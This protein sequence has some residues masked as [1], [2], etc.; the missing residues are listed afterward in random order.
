MGSRIAIMGAGAAGSYIGAFLT[1]DGEDVTLI[2]MWPEHVELMK[3]IGLRASGSQG[4]FTVPVKALHLT[5]A[6]EIK[7]P[8]DIVFLAV[9]SYDTEWATHFVKR[10]V[11]PSGFVASAQNCM[12]DELVTSIV[13]YGREV[14]C[15]MSHI[16]VAL[17]EPGHVIRGGEVGRDSGH[18]VFRVGELHGRI[19]PR[20]EH[21][22]SMLSSI[23]GAKVT[24]NI[25]GERWTKL[26]QN[27]MG[28]AVAAMSTLGSQ[29]MAKNPQ[30]RALR[31]HLARETVQV[32]QTLNF[33]LEPIA[34][35][36]PDFWARSDQG[37]VFEELDAY[38]ESHG[39]RVDWLASMAQDVKKGRRTEIDYMN[40][41]VVDRG[42]EVGVPTPVSEAV[43]SIV[44]EIDADRIAPDLLNIDRVLKMAG[45]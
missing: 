45:Y 16:E 36:D 2:D 43:V 32:G 10:F 35:F 9:K 42:Q 28:N 21:L 23:D 33:H 8:F 27:C 19:T 31:I 40:G 18:D 44:K 15:V 29:G 3:S 11:K 37:D 39:G 7:E 6:Q 14:G 17:W 5:E 26:T 38:L 1:R 4:D 12:N 13:G 25:W 20:V 34:D 22:A 41:L 24:T 30:A